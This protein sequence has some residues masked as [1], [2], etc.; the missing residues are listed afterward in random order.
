MNNE[1]LGQC[2][3]SILDFHKEQ[4]ETKILAN[5]AMC[6]TELIE[7]GGEIKNISVGNQL[8]LKNGAKVECIGLDN[9]KIIRSNFSFFY[10]KYE[11][12]QLQLLRKQ[13][14]LE[15]IITPGKNDFEKLLLLN[16][17]LFEHIEFGTPPPIRPNALQ[18]LH[19]GLNGQT[20]YC[21]YLSF[22]LMQMYTS[23]GYTARKLTS[24]GHGTLDVWSNYWHKWIQI[25]PS[26][27][28][29]FRLKKSA[30]P[31]NSNEIRREFW[32]NKGIDMEMVYGTEQ[33]AEKVTLEVRERDGNM[34]YRPD[35]YK[36][37]AYKSRNNF[38][39]VPFAYWNYDYLI[40]EDEYNSK[41]TWMNGGKTDI[42]EILGTKTNRIGDVFWTLN[43]AYIHIYD[44]G[45]NNLIVQLETVTPNFE[46]FEYSIDEG[47]WYKTEENSIN[48]GQWRKTEPLFKWA[49]HKGQNLLR[50]R[51]V[52]KFGV[53]GP[54]YKMVLK[55]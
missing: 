37:V 24:V 27:R 40:I 50:T 25:D 14:N 29:Y 1:Q 28:S 21:T 41:K 51:S 23:L 17:W 19:H 13:Y 12:K 52:N 30:I 47:N 35:S 33:R 53:R 31:L 46:P 55:M 5:I 43:Q 54:E 4:K 44:E 34:R 48:D 36:W 42:R 20:F 38:F 45:T 7:I 22:T 3:S 9:E 15:E 49:L 39:E 8:E 6:G 11:N 26:R 10:E 32:K 16:E 2:K 18:I